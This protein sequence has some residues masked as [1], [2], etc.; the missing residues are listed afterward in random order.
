VRLPG[1]IDYGAFARSWQGVGQE[2][3]P[4]TGVRQPNKLACDNQ[5]QGSRIA[6]IRV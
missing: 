6:E 5:K 1:F 2:T 3:E 4:E